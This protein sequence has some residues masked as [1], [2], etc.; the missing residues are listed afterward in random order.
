MAAAAGLLLGSTL[1]PDLGAEG[2]MSPQTQVAGGGARD[3]YVGGDPGLSR[4]AG[5]V[6]EYV[7]GT[8]ATRPPAEFADAG[9]PAPETP[10]PRPVQDEAPQVRPAP[11]AWRDMPREPVAYPSNAGGVVYETDLPPPPPPPGEDDPG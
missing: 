8:D 6:P 5:P 2:L 10:A 1:H 3:G 7:T 11:P 9:A 4:Y